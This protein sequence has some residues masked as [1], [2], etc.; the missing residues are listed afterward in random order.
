MDQ[1]NN[2]K[3]ERLLN[4]TSRVV[5]GTSYY[6]R[7][8]LRI[9]CKTFIQFS[10]TTKSCKQVIGTTY[11]SKSSPALEPQIYLSSPFAKFIAALIDLHMT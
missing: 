3:Y 8:I 11:Y 7:F 10:V 6:Y 9:V 1:E 4:V 5:M 2:A